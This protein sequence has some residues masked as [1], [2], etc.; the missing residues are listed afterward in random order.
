MARNMV[1]ECGYKTLLRIDIGSLHMN[2]FY[3]YVKLYAWE[4]NIKRDILVQKVKVKN[5]FSSS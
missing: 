3:K 5:L 1:V 4:T 2:V